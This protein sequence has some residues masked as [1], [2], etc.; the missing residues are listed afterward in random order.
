MMSAVFRFGS[1]ELEE[2]K[3]QAR[4][5]LRVQKYIYLADILEKEI[6]SGDLAFS[7]PEPDSRRDI[8]FQ[9][10]Q[11]VRLELPIVSSMVKELAPLVLYLRYLAGPDELLIIDEP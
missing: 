2:R 6:L 5:D 4:D 11:D 7:T 10:A 8:L 1:Q 3:A 9:A